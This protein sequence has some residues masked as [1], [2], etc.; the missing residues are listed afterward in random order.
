MN[1]NV[2][3]N[4][5]RDKVRRMTERRKNSRRIIKA[6]FGSDKWVRAIQASYVLW[7]KQ[8]RRQQDRRITS[9]RTLERREQMQKFRSVSL[10]QRMLKKQRQTQFL[11]AEEQA[12]LRELHN[13]F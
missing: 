5:Y 1:R 10:R 7:P 2:N 4:E 3:L 11:S 12:M 9:R 6:E 8:D 13:R